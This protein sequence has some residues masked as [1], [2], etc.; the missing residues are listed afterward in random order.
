MHW[1]ITREKWVSS[2]RIEGK[3]K[4]LGCYDDEKEASR[5]YKKEL[6]LIERRVM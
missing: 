4:H 3:S 2:I 1:H 6:K 5:A